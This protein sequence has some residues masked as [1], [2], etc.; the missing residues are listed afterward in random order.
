M[1]LMG[2]LCM[3]EGPTVPASEAQLTEDP[4]KHGAVELDTAGLRWSGQSQEPNKLQS[5]Q[6]DRSG[7]LRV[8]RLMFSLPLVLG[9]LLCCMDLR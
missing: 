6:L 1:L 3:Q 7:T 5:F 2:H 8:L 4:D 9:Y